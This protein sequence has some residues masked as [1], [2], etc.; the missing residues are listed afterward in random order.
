MSLSLRGQREIYTVSSKI[1]RVTE[2]NLSLENERRVEKICRGSR[3]WAREQ[4]QMLKEGT[5]AASLNL[6]PSVVCS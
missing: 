4:Q 5:H 2:E 3:V 1:A 6:S